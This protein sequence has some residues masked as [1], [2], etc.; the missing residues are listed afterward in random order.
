MHVVAVVNSKGGVGKTTIASALA[1]RAARESPRVAMVDLDPQRSLVEWWRRRGKTQNPT[2]F[3]GVDT[4]AEAVERLSQTGWDWVI[5][6]SPP[7]FLRVIEEVIA[8]ADLAVIPIRASILDLLA[9][10]DAVVLAQKVSTPFLCVL[11]DVN[12][13]DKLADEARSTLFTAGMPIADTNISHRVSH[14]AAMTAGK[15][16]AEVNGGKDKAAAAEIDALWLEVKA[17]VLAATKGKAKE[18]TDG[19]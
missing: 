11:N 13:R 8:A 19:R 12:S 6:D 16:A 5:V 10:Q 1:V 14:V 15:S 3:D 9:T 2:I 17:A 18:A 4:A 7:A